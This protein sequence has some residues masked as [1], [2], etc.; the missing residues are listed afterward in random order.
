ML[1]EKSEQPQVEGEFV[2]ESNTTSE[3]ER[4]LVRKCD[5]HILPIL[6]CLDTIAFMSMKHLC[7]GRALADTSIFVLFIP[8]VCFV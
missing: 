5:R 1:E 4:R 7:Q 8:F 3:A 6:F 2:D